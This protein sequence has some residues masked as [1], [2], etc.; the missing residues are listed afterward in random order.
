MNL[1]IST[2]MLILLSVTPTT[3]VDL[4]KVEH[5]ELHP[6]LGM[7]VTIGNKQYSYPVIET[8][9]VSDECLTTWTQDEYGITL[10]YN[11]TRVILGE[12]MFTRDICNNCEWRWEDNYESKN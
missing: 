2:A 8:T 6:T 5:F 1:L 4:S 12:L 7:I 3:P 10:C 11:K 9:F